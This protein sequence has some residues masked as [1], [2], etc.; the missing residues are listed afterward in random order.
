MR[1]RWRPVHDKVVHLTTAHTPDDSRIF[2]KECLSLAQAGYDVALAVPD[3]GPS[4]RAGPDDCVEIII[5]RRRSSRLG[6]ILMTPLAIAAAGLRQNAALYH[7]HDPE[8]IPYGMGLRLLGRKVVYD[9]HEDLPRDILFKAWIPRPLRV[10]IAWGSG[11]LEWL[12]GHLLSGVVAATPVIARRFPRHRTAL[13]QNFARLSEFSVH[14]GPPLRE[15]QDVAYVGAITR[16]RCALEMVDVLAL[17]GRHPG[18]RLVLAGPIQPASLVATLSAKEGWQR[19]DYRGIQDRAGVRRVLAEARVGLALFHP[20]QSYVESQPVKMFEYM[21][22]GLPVVASE[23]PGFR[24]II[25]ANQCGFCVSSNDATAIAEAI[26]WLFDHPA[27]AE[28][29]GRRGRSAVQRVFNWNR[30]AATLLR[31]YDQVLGR[32]V[33]G[34]PEVSYPEGHDDTDP[35]RGKATLRRKPSVQT[36][37]N[38]N[39]FC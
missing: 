29:M 10:P 20:V 22:A 32:P 3:S 18:L 19:V 1:R 15:R 12:A 17:L 13:V 23:F 11:A 33:I 25:E 21:A 38:P 7:F 34:H 31:L 16:E 37:S 5:V 9:A 27:E 36:P 35:A 2:W 39:S 30:E 6:R 4:R 28:A 26:S 14:D 24:A 8:L